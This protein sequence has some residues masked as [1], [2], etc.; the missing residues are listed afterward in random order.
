MEIE[1]RDNEGFVVLDIIGTIN[2]Y[3]TPELKEKVTELVEQGSKHLILNMS[4]VAYV[5]SPGLGSFI[6]C[7][8]IVHKAGGTLK[9]AGLTE[10]VS[11][12]VEMTQ[13]QAVLDIYEK[14]E[15]AVAR[16]FI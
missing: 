2:L 7:Q 13:L 12:A 15:D 11:K 5:D 1:T 4:E 16:G 3:K 8:N 6:S 10:S 14:E 9:L